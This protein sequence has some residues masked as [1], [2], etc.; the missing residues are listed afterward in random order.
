M[1]IGT[2]LIVLILLDLFCIFFPTFVV[3]LRE[4][5]ESMWHDLLPQHLMIRIRREETMNLAA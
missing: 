2:L 3:A 4:D 5:A 1:V